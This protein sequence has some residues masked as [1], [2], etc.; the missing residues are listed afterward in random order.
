MGPISSYN[1]PDTTMNLLADDLLIGNK[2]N[3]KLYGG[4]TDI[5]CKEQKVQIILFSGQL[6]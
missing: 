6:C 2:G 4:T 5:A 3:D 1:G